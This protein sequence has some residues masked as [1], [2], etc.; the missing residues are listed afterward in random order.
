M[1]LQ[2]KYTKYIGQKFGKL[3]VTKVNLSGLRKNRSKIY[4][5]SCVCDCGKE[6]EKECSSVIRGSTT[7]CGCRRDQYE[8]TKGKNNIKFNGHEEISGKYWAVLKQ[9]SKLRKHKFDITIEEAWNLFVLQDRKCFYTKQKLSFPISS[10]TRDW[11]E[12][13][14]SL[15]RIDSAGG[16]TKDNV[17]WVHKDI[18]LMKQRYTSEYF[19][20]LCNLVA[21]NHSLNEIIDFKGKRFSKSKNY[22]K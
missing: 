1:F 14:A 6:T 17:Q 7:S 9:S 20:H 15:D 8:K 16:Y 13:T 10:R 11:Q 18:N 5:F 2:T 19:V 21:K 3:K 22:I 4:S 12:F